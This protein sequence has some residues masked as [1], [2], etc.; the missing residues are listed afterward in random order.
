MVKIEIITPVNLI[1]TKP[2]PTLD[3]SLCVLFHGVGLLAIILDVTLCF[4]YCHE[5]IEKIFCHAIQLHE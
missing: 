3:C 5:I 4:V 1:D 2:T